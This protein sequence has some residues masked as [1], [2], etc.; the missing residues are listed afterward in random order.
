MDKIY[1]V[2]TLSYHA[3]DP[4]LVEPTAWRILRILPLSSPFYV[5]SR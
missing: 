1:L 5:F 3:S 2:S 4:S